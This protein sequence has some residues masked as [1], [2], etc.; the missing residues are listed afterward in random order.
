MGI[1]QGDGRAGHY[2]TGFVE[3]I[4][5]MERVYGTF[6]A[7]MF[8]E[9]NVFKYRSRIGGKEGEDTATELKKIGWYERKRGELRAKIG[10]EGE[11]CHKKRYICTAPKE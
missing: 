6:H 1:Y 2:N 9:M 7:A 4:D 11:I 5:Q 3:V 8:C 10:T